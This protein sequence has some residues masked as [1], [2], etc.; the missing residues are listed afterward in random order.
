[1]NYELAKQLKDAGFPQPEG[2]LSIKHRGIFF[3]DGYFPTLEE[4]IEA[5]GEDFE[6]LEAHAPEAGWRA[7]MTQEAF[8]RVVGHECVLDCCGYETGSTPTEA[9]A[10]LFLALNP[11]K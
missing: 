11:K 8:D 9:V 10:H 5:C 7:Y 1:M 4:L 6:N 2:K 3:Q